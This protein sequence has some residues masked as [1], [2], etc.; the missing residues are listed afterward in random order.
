MKSLHRVLIEALPSG[1]SL[2]K[3]E[4][5]QCEY[6]FVNFFG[7][8]FHRRAPGARRFSNLAGLQKYL[9]GHYIN[10]RS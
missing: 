9:Q 7:I 8:D 10:G 1:R 3:T 5:E 4:I 6:C 2:V